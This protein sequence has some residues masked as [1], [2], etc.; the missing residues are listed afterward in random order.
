MSGIAPEYQA[1]VLEDGN[2]KRCTVRE[3]HKGTLRVSAQK[4]VFSYIS[5]NRKQDIASTTVLA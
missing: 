5:S 4:K 1:Q 3:E 2:G